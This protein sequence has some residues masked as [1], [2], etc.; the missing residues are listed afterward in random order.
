MYL[1]CSGNLIKLTNLSNSALKPGG[2]LDVAEFEG[3]LKSDDGTLLAESN[4]NKYYDLLNEAAD[5][6]GK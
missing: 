4:L 3:R 6:S 5:K 2:W 1:G